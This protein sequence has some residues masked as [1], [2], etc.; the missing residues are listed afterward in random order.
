[1][2]LIELTVGVVGWVGLVELTVGVV[3]WVVTVVIG[4]S[5]VARVSSGDSFSTGFHTNVLVTNIG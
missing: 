3:G 5:G 2:V 4:N 1:M